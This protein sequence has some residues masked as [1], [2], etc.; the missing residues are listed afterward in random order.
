MLMLQEMHS[1]ASRCGTACSCMLVGA[2]HP[3]PAADSAS[4]L[5][6]PSFSNNA[7]GSCDPVASVTMHA[8]LFL[9]TSETGIP[10]TIYA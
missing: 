7:A 10:H 6:T 3:R 5:H 8:V 4:C 2:F 1:P 9:K